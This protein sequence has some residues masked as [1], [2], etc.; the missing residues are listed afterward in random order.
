MSDAEKGKTPPGRRSQG[1]GQ[2]PQAQAGCGQARSKPR[3]QTPARTPT[4]PVSPV[5]CAACRLG[6]SRRHGRPSRGA[7][8][9]WCLGYAP[10]RPH[11]LR[12][13][14]VNPS[15]GSQQLLPT[16]TQVSGWGCCRWENPWLIPALAPP[17]GAGVARTRPAP[18]SPAPCQILGGI[19]VEKPWDGEPTTGTVPPW[20]L[21]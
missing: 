2:E 17:P 21:R 20:C 4:V 14:T 9:A 8:A 7:G 12:V 15:L 10:S 13:F 18:H 5:P 16:I 11:L 6:G 1:H 3:T 19:R